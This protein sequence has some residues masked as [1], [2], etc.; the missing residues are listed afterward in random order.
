MNI[1]S[2]IQNS[3]LGGLNG[4]VLEQMN[5]ALQAA[6]TISPAELE[7]V[8]PKLNPAATQSPYGRSTTRRWQA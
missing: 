2:G 8:A 4:G 5:P 1:P 6:K 7:Q 3:L